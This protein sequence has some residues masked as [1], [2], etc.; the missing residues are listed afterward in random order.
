MA[1][2]A[3]NG[4]LLEHTCTMLPEA[5]DVLAL[6]LPV[7]MCPLERL[8]LS[9]N[10]IGDGGCEALARALCLGNRY[11]PKAAAQALDNVSE[12]RIALHLGA[13]VL[14]RVLWCC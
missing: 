13:W 5:R 8:V 10:H 1:L 12:V 2:R 7:G 4:D 3:L 6:A 14:R 11:S 9:G